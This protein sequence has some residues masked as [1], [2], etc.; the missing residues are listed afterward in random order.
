MNLTDILG[1]VAGYIGQ[2]KSHQ[3]IQNRHGLPPGS[4]RCLFFLENDEARTID[5]ED[6]MEAMDKMLEEVYQ[7]S[8]EVKTKEQKKMKFINPH[9]NLSVY[10]NIL[11]QSF[12]CKD[13]E[14]DKDDLLY[15]W[16]E[17]KHDIVNASNERFY[18]R[19][20]TGLVLITWSGK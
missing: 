19:S 12:Q 3:A 2:M 14:L 7:K 10:E 16:N 9:N 18:F 15:L 6:L 17:V 8:T 13:F 5:P 4:N 1:H 20:P 11:I